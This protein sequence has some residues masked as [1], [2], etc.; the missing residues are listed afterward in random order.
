M[1]RVLSV[2]FL[3]VILS[4]LSGAFAQTGEDAPESKFEDARLRVE[5]LSATYTDMEE[6]AL[7]LSLSK[8]TAPML[9][10]LKVTEQMAAAKLQDAYQQA[11]DAVQACPDL[12]GKFSDL[13]QRV[14]DLR[15]KSEKIQASEYKPLLVR[16]KDYLMSLAAV[17][18]LLMFAGMV[19]SKISAA[20]ALKKNAMELKKKLEDE[21][22]PKI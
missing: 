14:I 11:S 5:E 16:A 2:V 21:E 17:A 13:E 6:K 4:S 1:K 10:R 19:K 3:T 7:R 12:S 18:M 8:Q 9:R 22:Y 20:R 15:L